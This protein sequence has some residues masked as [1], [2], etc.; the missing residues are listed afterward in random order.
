MLRKYTYYFLAFLGIVLIAI[1]LLS[2]IQNISLWYLQILDFPRLQL[3]VSGLILIASI[4]FIVRRW[5]R[6]SQV[7]IIGLIISVVIQAVIIF[8]YT[9]FSGK[10]VA[11]ANGKTSELNKLSLMVA[12]VWLKNQQYAAFL[13]I[14]EKH[15]PDIVIAMEVDNRWLKAL[16]SLE[17]NYDYQVKR[18]FAN[19]YGM[20]LYSMFPLRETKVLYLNH[21]KVPSIC[22]NVHMSSR[23]VFNLHAVHP[24]PPKPSK[25]PDN[26][27]E[28]EIALISVGNMVANEKLP[29]VVAGDFNDVA[30]SK[31]ARLFK[32]DGQ[33]NDIRVGRGFYN[34]FDATS[35][36]MRWPLDHVYVTK[37]FKV[38]NVKRLEEF[39]SDHFP[40]FVEL[41]LP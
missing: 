26:V 14:I 13:D 22:T 33:L 27:G 7:L 5:T 15:K 40:F 34:S 12:N 11:N 24:V 39:G 37:E 18:P 25:H 10:E 41:Y 2:L 6:W 29:S 28:K 3:L 8:P 19:T 4:I 16:E 20:A 1:S 23:K 31:T 21:E 30:W 9:R 35:G 17:K 38:V 32:L 36:I